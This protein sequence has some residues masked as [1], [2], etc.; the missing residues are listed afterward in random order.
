MSATLHCAIV[1]PGRTRNGLAPFLA[2]FLEEAGVRVVAASG[3]DRARTSAACDALAA[4]LGHEIAP[5]VDVAAMLESV[6]PDALVI[7][8]PPAA[9]LAAL[10]A[11]ADAGVPTLC[12]KPLVPA[13]E[14]ARVGALLDRFAAKGVLLAENCQWPCVLPAFAKLW[15]VRPPGPPAAVAM[16]LS[17]TGRGRAMVEDSLS[18]LL[19]LVQALSEVGADTRLVEAA[20]AG[21]GPDTEELALDVT[22]AHPSRPPLRVRLELRHVAEQ[23][24]PAWLEIDGFRADR[25]VRTD[26]YSMT[27]VAPDGRWEPVDDPMR[28]L[29]Y[30][31]VADLREPELE[32]IRDQSDAIR[33]RA[34]FYAEI[35]ERWPAG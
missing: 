25:R 7:A 4:R 3:R 20:Y 33:Q 2:S 8:T 15:P 29:V 28:A 34:R 35:L 27:L 13:E 12:E 22:L 6:G 21:A 23:P 14:A 11:A 18:H 1:G 10:E 30:G 26:D 24:R 32:R 19:S 16:G 9:H 31:F 17:P 5:F